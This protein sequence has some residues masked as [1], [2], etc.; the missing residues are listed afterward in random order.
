V[1]AHLGDALE[2]CVRMDEMITSEIERVEQTLSDETRDI[3]AIQRLK[4]IPSVGDRVSVMLYAWIGDVKRF[5]S[6]RELASYAGLVPS[7]RQSGTSQQLGRIT[8]AGAP[9]L[10][11]VLVQAS[12][13]LMFR[14]RRPEAAPL[15][16]IVQRI[17]TGRG[18]RK[19]AVVAGARHILRIAY[20][21]L[22]DG[23]EYDPSLLR[24]ITKEEE[25]P[26]AA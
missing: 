25:Q 18:R 24:S 14:C 6:A 20:Y 22:R 3:D 23:T 10:R 2:L 9:Q 5:S 15:Q 17:H 19:I 8:K 12:H 21:I 16:A 11:S 1:D 26:S 13:V 7:V 4:T